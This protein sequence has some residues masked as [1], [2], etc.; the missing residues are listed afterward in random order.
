[1][2]KQHHSAVSSNCC[3]SSARQ[4]HDIM[5]GHHTCKGAVVLVETTESACDAR[6]LVGQ[7]AAAASAAEGTVRRCGAV[8]VSG[9]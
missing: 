8:N 2:G 7:T 6:M 1:M 9:T 4:D 5:H 3:G